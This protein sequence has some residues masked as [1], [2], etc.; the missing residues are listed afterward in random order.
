VALVSLLEEMVT[1]F[2]PDQLAQASH[3]PTSHIVLLGF[4]II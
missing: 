4:D 3:H 1:I 2:A